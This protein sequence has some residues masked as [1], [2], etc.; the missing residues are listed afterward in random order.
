MKKLLVGRVIVLAGLFLLSASCVLAQDCEGNFDCDQDVDGSDAFTFKEDFGRG[1][2]D[3]PC[4][5]C[6]D[7]PCPCSSCLYGMV[8]CGTKCVD[9]MTDRD[10]CGANG[11]CL[12]GTACEGDELC[13]NGICEKV[14]CDPCPEGYL[15][16]VNECIDPMTDPEHC[17]ATI[18]CEDGEVCGEHSTCVD[19]VC[20]EPCLPLGGICSAGGMSC[21][22]PSTNCCCFVEIMPISQ[23]SC[24]LRESCQSPMGHC[25]N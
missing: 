10:Y 17:G 5:T 20:T 24:Q 8:D 13:V 3:N 9:P 25:I 7:S 23:V 19:G 4:D 22:D 15:F 21:C 2:Y 12:G 14:L 11:E 18:G 16:C 1:E 6:V